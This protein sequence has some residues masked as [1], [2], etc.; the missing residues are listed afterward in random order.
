M[1]RRGG[2]TL[3][4][5]LV[6][7]VLTTFVGTAL[8]RV[9]MDETRFVDRLSNDATARAV[10]RGV[11]SVIQNELRMV[12]TGGGIIA[13]SRDSL[14]VLVPYA[15]GVSCGSSGGSTTIAL[16]P[17]D[18]AIY[19]MSGHSGH[20]YRSG[21]SYVYSAS[22][23][24]PGAG[25]ASTCTGAGVTTIPAIGTSPAGSVITVP[26]A[27]TPAP[28]GSVTVLYREITY[29]FA[30][31]SLISGSRALWRRTEAN[32]AAA[33]VAAPVDT[34]AKFRFYAYGSTTSQ[35][36]VPSP[37]SNIAGVEVVLAGTAESRARTQTSTSVMTS[38]TAIFFANRTD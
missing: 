23:A 19:A 37:L 18:S 25:S 7:V 30:N 14:R 33:E 2:F 36:A 38:T 21:S 5:L 20:A 34:S 6:A 28:A 11:S 10:S 1:T 8:V 27:T 15:I 17:P 16:V 12:E 31:S 22:T 13:A 3:V 24:A 35:S 26:N 9:V 4:E 29:Y 32:S